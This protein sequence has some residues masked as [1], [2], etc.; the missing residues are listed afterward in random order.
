[1]QV[2]KDSALDA[3][4]RVDMRR[5]FF[6]VMAREAKVRGLD[7]GVHLRSGEGVGPGAD[8]APDRES[9]RA[10]AGARTHAE[11]AQARLARLARGALSGR[12]S[13]ARP[14]TRATRA[15]RSTSRSVRSSRSFP[16]VSVHMEQYRLVS[17]MQ[18]DG[19][20][21]AVDDARAGALAWLLVAALLV[22]AELQR[23]PSWFDG[24]RGQTSPSRP[25]GSGALAKP[26]VSRA[27]IDRMGRRVARLQV[28]ARRR[29]T[30]ARFCRVQRIRR[31]LACSTA[32]AGVA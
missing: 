6:N 20:E 22:L 15:G 18:G 19:G 28:V 26:R 11:G 3:R 21:V 31:Q 4:M 32:P 8:P 13:A 29:L 25:G 12:T 16:A 17:H 7:R 9:G 5:E 27:R 14:G 24:D 10:P 2:T 30:V 1:M 23:E